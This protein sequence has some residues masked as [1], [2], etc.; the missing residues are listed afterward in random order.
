MRALLVMAALTAL[1]GCGDDGGGGFA[2]CT[3]DEQCDDGVFCSGVERCAPEEVGASSVGCVGGARPCDVGAACIEVEDRCEGGCTTPDGDGDG[4]ERIAC[5]GAD[6]DDEDAE[7]YPGNTEVCDADGHDEDCDL[8]TIGE[9]DRDRDGFVDDQC[10]NVGGASGVDCNDR[11]P[12]VSP[13]GEEACNG[14]D[15]DCDGNVDEG[16]T[17]DGFLDADADGHGD[18]SMAMRACLGRGRFAEVGDDCDDASPAVF[19]GQVEICDGEDNDCDGL[20]DEGT[21]PVFWF[22]DADADGYGDAAGPAVLSCEPVAGHALLPTDCDDGDDAVNPAELESCNGVDDDCNGVADFDAGDGD[23]EDDDRDGVAD[24]RCGGLDCDDRDPHAAGTFAELCNGRDDDCDGMVDEATTASDWFV[25]LDGDGV[26]AGSA[27]R[28]C[29]VGS[30]FVPTG[31]DCNDGDRQVLPGATERCNGVDDD[32]DGVVDERATARCSGPDAVFVCGDGYCQINR[33]PDGRGDCDGNPAN[34]CEADILYDERHCG[35]CGAICAGTCRNGGCDVG[36]APLRSITVVNLEG[37]AITDARYGITGRL[38]PTTDGEFELR[39]QVHEWVRVEADGFLPM[40]VPADYD[41]FTHGNAF[42]GFGSVVM[43]RTS[44]VEDWEG[45]WAPTHGALVLV[46]G[47]AAAGET[48]PV[49]LSLDH[50]GAFRALD[51]RPLDGSSGA[52]FTD[53]SNEV[54]VFTDVTPGVATIAAP[55]CVLADPNVRI[56]PGAI[57]TAHLDCF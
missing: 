32:C 2:V 50:G 53:V 18:P 5:G 1:V 44:E 15:D 22:P 30:G 20:T 26:G 35:A 8:N 42:L 48:R 3:S 54:V 10:A 47:T 13:I 21:R 38:Y 39:S 7:R 17:I 27:M 36:S 57:T 55:G 9:L 11:E 14:R 4:V 45:T 56:Y 28:M 41:G 34:G 16:V 19:A 49:V 51:F 12:G 52:F 43:A 46:G 23:L 24:E 6:C 37:A 25:D 31:T 40:L 29:I 33:C